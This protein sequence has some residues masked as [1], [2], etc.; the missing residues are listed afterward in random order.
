MAFSEVKTYNAG[1]DST[2]PSVPKKRKFENDAELEDA[3]TASPIV[4]KVKKEA[5]E[6]GE[7][8]KGCHINSEVC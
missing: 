7:S 5:S 1:A 4:K 2:L 6:D 8:L 3:Q